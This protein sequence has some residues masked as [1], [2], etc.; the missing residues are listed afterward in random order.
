MPDKQEPSSWRDWTVKDWASV[1]LI[2]LA[3]YVIKR[4]LPDGW[5][6]TLGLLAFIS[7][8]VIVWWR[9]RGGDK[10]QLPAQ[11]WAPPKPRPK[12]DS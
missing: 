7:F 9:R 8:F 10:H 11:D 3:G 4:V 12:S 2:V 5:F 1:V 6:S